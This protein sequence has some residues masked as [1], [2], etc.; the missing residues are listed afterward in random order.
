[1]G[2]RLT[3]TGKHCRDINVTYNITL[4][5]GSLQYE[6]TSNIPVFDRSQRIFTV[7]ARFDANS[8]IVVLSAFAVGRSRLSLHTLRSLR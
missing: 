8:Q 3:A 2:W 6:K 4:S 5:I 1:M 7:I